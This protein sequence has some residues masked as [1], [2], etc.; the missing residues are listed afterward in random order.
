MRLHQCKIWRYFFTT[1]IVK[2]NIFF[3]FCTK[4]LC[5]I[6]LCYTMLN[7]VG[8]IAIILFCFICYT[9]VLSFSCY[10][11][12]FAC[13]MFSYLHS[14]HFIPKKLK[15][16]SFMYEQN[17]KINWEFPLWLILLESVYRIQNYTWCHQSGDHEQ[18]PRWIMG[19]GGLCPAF[20][21]WG[22]DCS[23]LCLFIRSLHV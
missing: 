2:H 17:K 15:I 11:S 1:I 4:P 7:H 10:R 13:V 19:N 14:V 3:F 6:L 9:A 20:P 8:F 21:L 16:L 12:V 5:T 23:F 22:E 18:T